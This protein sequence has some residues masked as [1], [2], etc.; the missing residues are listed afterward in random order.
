MSAL[1]P[2]GDRLAPLPSMSGHRGLL[3][4][5]TTIDHKQIAI[6][7]IVTAF[8]FFLV[9][10][11][12][13]I[14][15]RIQ[16]IRPLNDF[17]LPSTYNQ[18]FTMHGT[19]MIFLMAMPLLFGFA[20]YFVP[21][22]IGAR[23]MAFPRLN[24][25]GYWL[26]LFGAL[27]LYF[28][29]M[30][31]GAPSAGWFSYAPLT[32]KSYS[33]SPG[34]DYWALS[35]LLMGAG[36]VATG[37]NL[38][39][40]ILTLRTPGMSMRRLPLFVWLIFINA[41]LVVVALPPLNAAL[42]MILI[43]RQL[44]A[45]FFAP[46]YGGS[47]LL[48]QNYFWVFGHPEVYIL[49]LPAFGVISEVIPVFSRKVIYGY[50]FMAASTIAIG[51]LSVGVWMHHMFATGLGSSLLYVF[52]VSSMLIAVPTGIKIWNWIATMWGGTIRFT[53]AM[54]FATAFL[55]QFTIGG[56][57]GVTFAAIPIDWQLTDSYFVVAH[58]HYVLLGGT[59]FAMFA[60]T[61]YWFPKVTG[62]RLSESL[63]KLHFWLLVFGFN[64]TFLVMHLLGILGMPR[65]AYTYADRPHLATL[66]LIST[67]SAFVLACAILVFICN[68][69]ASLRKGEVAGDNPWGGWTLEWATQSPPPVENFERVPPVRGRRPLRDLAHP[70]PPGYEA[71]AS[72]PG[73]D[74]LAATEPVKLGTIL[75]IGS[76][77]IFFLL[78]ILAYVFYHTSGGK[79]PTAASSLNVLRTSVFSA[80]LFASSLTIWLAGSSLKNQKRPAFRFWVLATIVL[81]AVFLGGQASEYAGL[82]REH[83]TISRNLFGSTFFTL[84]GFH[85]FHVLVGLLLLLIL[86]GL[87]FSTNRREPTPAAVHTISMYWHFVDGVWMVIFPIVY[88]WKFV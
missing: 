84:T 43:D 5:I 41:F 85:G 83:V 87:A 16:L 36:S 23:D 6:L 58:I 51:F 48:W 57:A 4:W 59:L 42:V 80:A 39:V 52:A 25:L 64:G 86:F 53:T 62:R 3:S 22:M 70:A 30:A 72:S 17:L 32:E 18:I 9:G 33:F 67:L 15:M 11:C 61:Y 2:Q 34:I 44:N 7:Y 10:V 50:G 82:L 66:Q 60:G 74:A 21:L 29:F 1:D 63:G 49:A 54:M 47:A 35:L 69:V 65:R 73:P 81:G 24:A 88:L 14:A 56:L 13:A 77:S 12:E 31:G 68:V 20:I 46:A 8:F 75:F 28:S 45:H 79:G 37:I 76:E 38:I 55:L 40:T 78:L 71:A 19:T 27:M 26:Y